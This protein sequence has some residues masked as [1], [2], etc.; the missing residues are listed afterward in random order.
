MAASASG[1]PGHRTY[2]Q[3]PSVPSLQDFALHLDHRGARWPHGAARPWSSPSVWRG[4]GPRRRRSRWRSS[5]QAKGRVER[6]AG[7]FQDRLVTELRLAKVETTDQAN[8]VLHRYVPQFDK[9]FGI[10]AA[11][12]EVAYRLPGTAVA[13]EQALCFRNRRKVGKD[14]TVKYRWRTLQLL[15]G[16]ER[17]SYAGVRVEVLERP[18]GQLLVE[19]EGRTIPTQEAPPRPSLMRSLSPTLR[20]RPSLEGRT[21]GSGYHDHPLAAL[22]TLG[23]NGATSNRPS[24]VRKACSSDT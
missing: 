1:P 14:N 13:V 22:E 8:E 17:P 21:N 19:Y 24:R 5:S 15:P 12:S 2:T 9:Q 23:A 10:P 3:L 20:H 6:T 4:G 11:Q 16:R 18:D 7:T